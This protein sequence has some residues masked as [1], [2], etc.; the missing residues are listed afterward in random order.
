MHRP[1]RLQ[2]LSFAQRQEQQCVHE[3]SAADIVQ[4]MS[5]CAFARVSAT[6]RLQNDLPQ[7]FSI[8]IL[9]RDESVQSACQTIDGGVV[10]RI[11]FIREDD[12]EAA[13]QLLCGNISEVLRDEGESNEVGR[14]G[15]Q[16][17][18]RSALYSRTGC[19]TIRHL[20]TLTCLK[21]SFCVSDGRSR[22]VI[23]FAPA[24][25]AA[26]VGAAMASAASALSMAAAG[27]D[28]ESTGYS[29]ASAPSGSRPIIASMTRHASSFFINLLGVGPFRLTCLLGRPGIVGKQS[30][31]ARS[32]NNQSGR[33]SVRGAEPGSV[34]YGISWGARQGL[35]YACALV[36]HLSSE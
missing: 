30:S 17:E 8:V 21:I 31:Y 32:K 14:R 23:F 6:Q 1:E 11:I 2:R 5:I 12:V 28:V 3:L 22:M 20:E 13:V 16:E 24:A 35:R 26:T 10:R 15:L 7:V 29:S 18:G 33:L 34:L 25:E 27:D 4:I 36:Q 9:A 19:I